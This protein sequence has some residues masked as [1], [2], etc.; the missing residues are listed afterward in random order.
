ML[1][2]RLVDAR[3]EG[4]ALAMADGYAQITGAPGICTTTSGPGVT[5][6]ARVRVVNDWMRVARGRP[7]HREEHL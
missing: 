7:G 3:H 2:V 4:V 1:G 5:Q 6:V